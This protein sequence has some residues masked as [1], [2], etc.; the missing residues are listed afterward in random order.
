MNIQNCH[1]LAIVILM[2]AGLGL[3][4]AAVSAAPNKCPSIASIKSN[5]NAKGLKMYGDRYLVRKYSRFDTAN[6]WEFVV[7]NK[8]HTNVKE[9]LKDFT[10][11]MASL[12]GSPKPSDNKGKGTWFCEYNMNNHKVVANYPVL[13]AKEVCA[14]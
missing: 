4:T 7:T 6:E 3:A 8:A 14:R 11:N 5:V 10:N 2:S 13:C 1:K 9:D 12:S